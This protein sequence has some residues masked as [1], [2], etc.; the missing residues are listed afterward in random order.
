MSY[1]LELATL[2]LL[3]LVVLSMALTRLPRAAQHAPGC[4]TSRPVRQ[5]LAAVEAEQRR[6][7]ATAGRH[8]LLPR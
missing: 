3:D 8:R 4:T 7:A 1:W 2:A 6:E 5:L